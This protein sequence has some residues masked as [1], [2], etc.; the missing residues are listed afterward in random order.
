MQH[1]RMFNVVLLAGGLLAAVAGCSAPTVSEKQAAHIAKEPEV[2]ASQ[3]RL[4]L[5]SQEQY[6]RSI[7]SIFGSDVLPNVGFA[8]FQRTEGLVAT[9]AA[10]DAVNETQVELYQRAATYI[11]DAVVAPERREFLIPCKPANEKAAD[12][13]CATK[14]L[15]YAGQR[16]FRRPLT[17][18]KQAKL[19]GEAGAFADRL[20]DFYAGIS[21]VL[22]GM[23]ASPKTLYIEEI[24]E[25]DPANPG[26]RRLDSYSLASRLSFFLWD[27]A[28]DDAL[29]AAAARGDLYTAK[30]RAKAVDAML[31]STNLE[32]GVRA[33]FND[34]LG[35][36]SFETLAK[37]P[38]VY[39]SFT[40]LV[41]Q[42]ARE[43]SLRLL[44]DQLVR[45]NGDYR[46][47]FT[48]HVAFVSKP[49]A[50]LYQRRAVK[51]WTR[52][53]LPADDP[54]GG[55]LTQISF[56]ALHSHPGRSS[57]TLRGKA[58]R[59]LLL[60]QTVPPPPPNVDFSAVENPDP[61]LKTARD[62]LTRHRTNPVCAGCHKIT[63]PIGL[64]LENFD[65]SGQ[66]RESEK[67]AVIDA[68]GDLDG[69]SFKDAIGLGQALHDH[70]GVPACL[71]KRAYTYASGGKIRRDD[72]PLLKYF[73]ERFAADG[74][75]LPNLMRTI[76]L[77]D[78]IGQ[79][80]ESK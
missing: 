74:Y 30:G 78:A 34:M 73:N 61:T 49:L 13:A 45:R 36:D 75:R 52:Y 8:P 72:D 68:S 41:A 79:V 18:E 56:L 40:G 60:C 50:P 22:E 21:M 19:V 55:F 5:L 77:S 42:D 67:G 63:D 3:T 46:D 25:P 16:L 66:F 47:I 69:K 76:A 58:L 12:S 4:R 71:V 28:P 62:R 33:F 64:A 1:V 37:D 24:T 80:G 7:A 35:F 26:Q 48:T 20:S 2:A 27:Q 59:E 44:V 17:A 14:F 15:G 23:L 57:A 9:G 70:P 51:N 39:P 10:Y 43:Q 31:A 11:A 38:N 54:R 32:A 29:L 53:E 65:G 6:F